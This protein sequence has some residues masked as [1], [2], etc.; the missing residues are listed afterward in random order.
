M[1]IQSLSGYKLN[2]TLTSTEIFD[3]YSILKGK[4]P[5]IK[6]GALLVFAQPR[7]SNAVKGQ[8]QEPLDHRRRKALDSLHTFA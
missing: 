1:G 8:G 6:T 5:L 7:L 3:T 4:A 2:I